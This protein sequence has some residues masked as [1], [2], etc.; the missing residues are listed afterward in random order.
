ML[1]GFPI[2]VVT[3]CY[4]L[5]LKGFVARGILLLAGEGRRVL[6]LDLAEAGLHEGDLEIVASTRSHP[7]IVGRGL[8]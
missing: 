4:K 6:L 1:G 8:R 5:M 7:V 3:N 2:G